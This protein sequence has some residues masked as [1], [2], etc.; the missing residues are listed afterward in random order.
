M[1]GGA[2]GTGGGTAGGAAVLDAK[3][4]AEARARTDASYSTL[5]GKIQGGGAITSKEL[6]DYISD[7]RNIERLGILPV[8]LPMTILSF[9][10]NFSPEYLENQGTTQF[11]QNLFGF[12]STGFRELLTRGASNVS[13]CRKAGYPRSNLPLVC[14]W[15]GE[16]I[17]DM[18]ECEHALPI[19]NCAG[20]LG[21]SSNPDRS[22]IEHILEYGY[23]HRLCNQVKLDVPFLT[24]NDGTN[25]WEI[26]WL[27]MSQ[28]YNDIAHEQKI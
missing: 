1:K 6:Y 27:N 22:R 17:Y 3:D 28:V 13:Q 8:T 5:V 16:P 14:I 25:K 7:C 9:M 11:C 24:W 2:G 26:N 20:L 19:L 23:A 4:V 21:F 10:D 18:A 15:C 12:R